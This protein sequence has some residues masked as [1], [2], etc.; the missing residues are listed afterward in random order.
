VSDSEPIPPDR[1]SETAI[2]KGVADIADGDES[3]AAALAR[4]LLATAGAQEDAVLASRAAEFL[5][6]APETGVRLRHQVSYPHG[7]LDLLRGNRERTLIDWLF[8]GPSFAIAVEVKTHL[9]GGMEER[10]LWRYHVAMT[11]RRSAV[12]RAQSG[13]LALTP[14]VLDRHELLKPRHKRYL[15]AIRWDQAMPGLRQLTPAD[16][17]DAAR[18]SAILDHVE[19]S[20]WPVP[21]PDLGASPSM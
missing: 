9:V 10:Q 16:P 13:V 15:G 20:P 7:W 3:F 1:F 19:H 17:G 6:H 14:Y 8:E 12:R 21:D 11:A 18:W 5:R 2:T 4:T